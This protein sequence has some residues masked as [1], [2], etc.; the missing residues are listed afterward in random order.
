VASE[1]V[2]TCLGCRQRA[3]KSE[4]VRVTFRVDG[5][6]RGAVV[7]DP[8]GAA[9]GRGAHLHPATACYELAVRRKAFGRALRWQGPGGLD[10]APVATY[11]ADA[12][13]QMTEDREEGWSSSS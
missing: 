3:A 2:R 10:S 9:P 13:A 11:V 7:V 1:P 5:Q 12:E 8:R 6:G 4:L